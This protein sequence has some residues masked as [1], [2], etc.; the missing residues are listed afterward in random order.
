MGSNPMALISTLEFFIE[1]LIFT[2]D[3]V[4]FVLIVVMFV[5]MREDKSIGG[6][7]CSHG[8]R[9]DMGSS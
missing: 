1:V 2:R 3:S 4:C 9:E 5:M 6:E 7:E 8:L